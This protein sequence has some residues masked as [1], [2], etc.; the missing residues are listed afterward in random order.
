VVIPGAANAAMA[1][2]A[3]FTPR[4]VLLRVLEQLQ[5]KKGAA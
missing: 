3:A 4:P 1:R 5:K 2:S